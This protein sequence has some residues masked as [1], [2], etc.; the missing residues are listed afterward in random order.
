MEK[1][2]VKTLVALDWKEKEL[3]TS[4]SSEV[5]VFDI[6]CIL[7]DYTIGYFIGTW[8]NGFEEVDIL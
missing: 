1:E 7:S 4:A 2:R 3:A 6:G 5:V 8:K